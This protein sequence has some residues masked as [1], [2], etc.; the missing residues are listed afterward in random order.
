[1]T[2]S[3]VLTC[4]SIINHKTTGKTVPGDFELVGLATG[5]DIGLFMRKPGAGA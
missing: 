1:M 2:L 5:A 3:T 4:V